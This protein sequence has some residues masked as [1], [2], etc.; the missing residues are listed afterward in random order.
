MKRKFRIA[1]GR[2]EKEREITTEERALKGLT[3][4]GG[5]EGGG[6]EV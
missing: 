2:V 4:E 6:G 3:G 5:E 1:E